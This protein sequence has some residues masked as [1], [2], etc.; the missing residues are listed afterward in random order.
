MPIEIPVWLLA[1]PGRNWH[2]ATMSAKAASSSQRR[3][4]RRTRRGNS[5]DAR[6]ARRT[7]SAPAAETRAAPRAPCRGAAASPPQHR[8]QRS[9]L[10]S[11]A[12]LV[13]AAHNPLPPPAGGRGRGEGGRRADD[14]GASHLTLPLLRNGPLSLPPKGRRGANAVVVWVSVGKIGSGR[15]R[16]RP[17]RRRHALGAAAL[18][19]L[20]LWM[21]P[22]SV[23]AVGSMTALISAG[24][25]EASA[26]V[27]ASVRLG[28][29]V[30]VVAGA[31]ERLDDLLVARVAQQAGRRVGRCRP[32]RRGR[33]R[34]C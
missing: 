6:P 32:G 16:T 29:S 22:L 27:S 5:R 1:G 23:P 8:R 31:A 28:V 14:A 20:R 2:S 11:L 24:L 33:R 21:W 25:P 17:R 13:P 12:R 4:A 9:R 34:Y 19:G 30:H 26:S 15:A 3:G 10:L 7:W 18:R